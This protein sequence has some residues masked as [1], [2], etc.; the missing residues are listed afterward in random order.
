MP[1]LGRT[2]ATV[3]APLL[4]A[5]SAAPALAATGPHPAGAAG[6]R[7]TPDTPTYVSWE[8]QWS[9]KFMHVKGGS[10]ANNAV[11]NVDSDDGSCAHHGSANLGCDE[12]WQQISTGYAHE[13]AYKNVNSGKCLTDDQDLLGA[14]ILQYSCG[15]YPDQRRWTYR[16][17]SPGGSPIDVLFDWA[18]TA[19]TNGVR[20]NGFACEDKPGHSTKLVDVSYYVAESY[21][22]SACSWQ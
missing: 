10:T 9:A 22:Y 6:P 11:V 18:L 13:F 19:K 16:D 4:A 1:K 14:P 21:G 2:L 5:G 3:A 12:E 8:N 15:S 17:T 7:A 20:E